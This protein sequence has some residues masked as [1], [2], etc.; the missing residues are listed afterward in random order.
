M[1]ALFC[2]GSCHDDQFIRSGVLFQMIY[3]DWE[4]SEILLDLDVWSIK[5]LRESAMN[6]GRLSPLLLG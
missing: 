1:V 4:I 5:W 2:I 3:T 6:R